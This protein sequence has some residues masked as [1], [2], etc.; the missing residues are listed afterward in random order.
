MKLM[1]RWARLISVL[2]AVALV[3]TIVPAC[4]CPGSEAHSD[5]PHGCCT[6][7]PG[8]RAAALG[9]CDPAPRDVEERAP[10]TAA[11]ALPAPA[12]LAAAP[13]ASL[14]SMSAVAAPAAGLLRHTAP[15]VL[16]I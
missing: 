12:L 2:L 11:P 5:D 15:S 4:P 9:C 7:E 6:P 10:G 1:D 16:R 3:G 8:L 14:T 13:L